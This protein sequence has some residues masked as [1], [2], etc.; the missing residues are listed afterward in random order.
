MC[1]ILV[2]GRYREQRNKHSWDENICHTGRK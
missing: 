2:A 1:N